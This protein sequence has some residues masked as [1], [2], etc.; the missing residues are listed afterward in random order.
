MT[1]GFR[2]RNEAW[3]YLNSLQN[4]CRNI[5]NRLLGLM[6]P[7]DG[8]SVRQGRIRQMLIERLWHVPPSGQRYFAWASWPVAVAR[9][10][11][12]WQW[13]VPESPFILPVMGGQK[14]AQGEICHKSWGLLARGSIRARW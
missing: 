8:I 10:S 5:R 9:G 2:L 6:M 3:C 1:G 7:S 12:P 13:P 11:W 4:D 14:S